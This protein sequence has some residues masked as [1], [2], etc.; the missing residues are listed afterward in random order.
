LGVKVN[1]LWSDFNDNQTNLNIE[2]DQNNEQIV[3]KAS[4][5][6]HQNICLCFAGDD[7]IAGKQPKQS[8][9]LAV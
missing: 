9:P 2:E 7:V 1:C 8:R 3:V 4:E 5:S 6:V